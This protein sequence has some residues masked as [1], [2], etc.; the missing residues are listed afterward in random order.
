MGLPIY[1]RGSAGP[2]YPEPVAEDL[3]IVMYHYVRNF[4]RTRYPRIKGLD[5][6]GFRR[7][8]DHLSG[9]FTIVSMQDVLAAAAGVAALPAAA[10]LLTFDDGYAEHY[11]VVFPILHERRLQGSFFPPVEPVVDG[12][13]LDVNRVHFI[14]ASVDTPQLVGAAIDAEVR[15]AA[16]DR[17]E[18]VEAYRA[19]WAVAN[20]FDDAETI[21][22]K[23]MLQTALPP[24]VRHRIAAAL[25]ARFVSADEQAFAGE[26]YLTRDQARVMVADGMFFG[27]HGRAHL[28]LNHADRPTQEAEIDG[29]LA[30]LADIGMPIDDGWVMC[31]PYGGWSDDLLGVLRQ[32]R[33]AVGLTTRVATARVGSRLDGADDPLLLPRYDTN[34]FPQ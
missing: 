8:L 30:F 3:T 7:Q 23:R 6:A 5:V 32:R 27:S 17:L 14:L 4:A 18:T 20:R 9:R 28:W 29:S 33:C 26:L 13:M 15:G 16:D 25:F 1:R 21:Y 24:D 12:V 19:A 31:Y 22:V 34:D 10:A 11:D 2:A